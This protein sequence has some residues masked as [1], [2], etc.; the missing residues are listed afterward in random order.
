M[1]W[2]RRSTLGAG[3]A[4]GALPRF[5]W[6]APAATSIATP[7][8]LS[9]V[10]LKPSIFLTS[11][12]ANARYLLSLDAD[13][14]LHNFHAGAGLPTRGK[15]YG[16]WESRG[17]AGHSLG[18]YMSAVSLI[19]A[20]TGDPQ[21]R[22]RA[23]YIV[24]Q[25]KAIQARHGDGYAGGTTVDR[26]GKTVDGKVVYEE[27]R[28]GE[29]RSTGFSL[30][31]GWVPLYTYH[32]IMAG[33]LD[34]HQHAGIKDGLTVAI[35]L[36]DYLGKILE[37]LSDTQVQDILRT[38]HGGLTES[39]AE[40]YKRTGN[41]RWLTL[42]ERM[43]HHAIVDPLQ[44]GRDELAG[45]HANTQIPKIIGEARL[46]ELTGNA[47]RAKVAQFFWTTVTR[48][49]SY[50]IGGN[51]DHEHFGLPRQL[52]QRLDQQT[53]EACNS[54][55]MLRLTRHL[56]SWSG[57]ASYFD[58]YERA[59]LNHIMSQQ[60]PKTGMFTYFT[61]LA[62]GM[63][64]VHSSPTEDFWCCVGSGMESHS[65]HGESI[66]WKRGD[67]VAINLYYA[68]TLNAPEAKLDMD[69]EFPLGN[70][71]R[72]AVTNAPKRLALRVPG[73][74]AD[75]L[76]KVNGKTA[77]VRD[78]GY[79]MLTGLKAGDRIELSLPMPVR[80]ESMPDDA[81]LVAFVSG[82]LVLAG[83]MGPGKGAWDGLDPAIVTDRA[84][85]VLVAAAGLHH[86]RL[87]EQGKPG[88]LTLRPF[89][90]QH[91]NR[92][93]V[94]FRR[95]DVAEWP[96]QEAAWTQ[97]SK[98]RA[99][100]AARTID[101]IRLGEQQPEV[102]HAFAD[103]GQSAPVS[104]VAD[105]SRNVNVGFFEFDLAVA[106]GPLALQVAYGGR[107]RDKDFRIMIDSEQL[108]RERLPGESTSARNVQTYALPTKMTQ[109]KSKIRVRFESDKWQGVEV[110]TAR[111]M[112]LKSV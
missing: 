95:F 91:E 46:H 39:Y 50:V 82:P 67:A 78:G 63:G 40:L 51:S 30:N 34:A 33:A 41:R 70:M 112:R 38:E 29:I 16:G 25:L 77:G 104:H 99:D 27:L 17:I 42:S 75:P 69:T 23:A 105:R 12:R 110:Y 102:D 57:E 87:G 73:W 84:E 5:T 94:Y 28:R 44:A 59:H 20:Q 107:Q 43:R 72:I 35:G 11:V 62:P 61:A 36:G 2:T 21:F 92:T 79:L 80:V 106:P 10:R 64:R 100:L 47:D 89:F 15:V 3:I 13:R 108:V 14:L 65:K 48:D 81:K 88:D 109:G 86:Y 103:S 4:F 56:Y 53:C 24:G 74:C 97:A 8:S 55:N 19:H 32:K 45:K 1:S 60:D 52:A 66:Y 7:F 31:D 37:G 18:H 90:A 98:D 54:Y 76:L 101:V 6:A 26:D 85:P 96:T 22:D 58:F 93:A 71:V 49:H 111:T 83:D 68:S 9:Q